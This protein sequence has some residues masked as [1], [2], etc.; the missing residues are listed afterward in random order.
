PNG[1]NL[2]AVKVS[3]HSHGFEFDTNDCWALSGIYRDVTL[4]AVPTVYVTGFKSFTKLQSDGSALL[5]VSVDTNTPTTGKG[6]LQTADGQTAGEFTFTSET[7]T[8]IAV[9][10]PQLW[11][12]EKPYLYT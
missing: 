4:F 3:T 5:H 11:S 7:D 6:T 9:P 1:D 10:Y 12:A 8:T 2:L